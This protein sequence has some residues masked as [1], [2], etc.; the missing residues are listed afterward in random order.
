MIGRAMSQI[1][2]ASE[3]ARTAIYPENATGRTMLLMQKDG[4]LLWNYL[5]R[6]AGRFTYVQVDV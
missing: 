4:T 5:A 3:S 2:L 1:A 6:L